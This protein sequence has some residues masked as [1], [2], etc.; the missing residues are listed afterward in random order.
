MNPL[1][2]AALE[3][4]R[5][6]KKRRWRFCIIGALA[7]LRWGEPRTTQHVDIAL[8]TRIG[9]ETEVID[10][11]LSNLPERVPNAR[12]FAQRNRVI[13][14]SASNGVGVD[15][16][17]ACSGIE[18]QMIARASQFAFAPRHKLITVSAE[19]L[20]VLKAFADRGQDWPDVRGVIARQGK[21]LDWKQ[22]TGDLMALCELKED[23]AP[24]EKLDA[25]RR[26]V[27]RSLGQRL[28]EE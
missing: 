3:V 23:T 17:L 18:E 4:Q 16:S 19:D 8:L 25:L 24:L 12:E 5:F 1:F 2:P 10:A 27:E 28:V 13:L 15:I 22:I 7:V 21:K 14:C 26:R 6:L 20:I 9:K 11:V